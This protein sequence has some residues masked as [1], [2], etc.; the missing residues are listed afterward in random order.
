MTAP[1]TIK[2]KPDKLLLDG[3]NQQG[4]MVLLTATLAFLQQNGISEKSI[5][6]FVR[7]YIS[8][9]REPRDAKRYA[10]LVRNYEEMGVIMATWFS[11]P[12]FL[13][14]YGNPL[15]L[16]ED[17]GPTSIT[18]L[19]RASRA[20]VKPAVALQLMRQSPS[21]KFTH[22]RKA[23]ALRRVFV[24]PKLEVLRAA[25]IIERY[26]DTLQRNASA[27]K[28]ETLLLLERSCHVSQINLAKTAPMLRDIEGRGAAFMDSIDGE[29]E[30][31]RL[32]QAQRKAVGELGVLV[33]AWTKPNSKVQGKSV[34][35]HSPATRARPKRNI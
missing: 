15:S 27:R 8:P 20:R 4:A 13:D 14:P 24:L 35:S 19:V 17:K 2:K 7:R 33:F 25:F 28:N 11:N 30:N 31:R 22:D 32:R 5:L 26:L 9:S 29:I 1:T 10:N 12:K 18:R 16:S 3:L 34:A 23:V 6:E 21:I